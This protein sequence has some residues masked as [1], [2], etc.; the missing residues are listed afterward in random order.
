MSQITILLGNIP[1]PDSVKHGISVSKDMKDFITQ[2]LK[3]DPE[4]RLGHKGV[5]KN[6]LNNLDLPSDETQL[7][8]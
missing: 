6:L 3:K 4:G 8:R 5:I 1:W 7:V 2:L